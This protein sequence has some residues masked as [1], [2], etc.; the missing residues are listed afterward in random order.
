[1]QNLDHLTEEALRELV[2]TLQRRVARLEV[3][4]EIALR[5]S[6]MASVAESSHDAI[7]SYGL[8]GTILSWNRGAE[9]MF[10]YAPTEVIGHGYHRLVPSEF[11]E[12]MGAR[13]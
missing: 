8:D 12:Q 3:E 11:P 4:I 6:T 13:C 7:I 10:G 9:E 5:R 2:Q 1:M